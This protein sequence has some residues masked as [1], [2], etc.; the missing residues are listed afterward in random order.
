MKKSEKRLVLSRETVRNLMT[1]AQDLDLVVVAGG[2]CTYPTGSS[3]SDGTR[4]LCCD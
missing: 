1:P 4:R 3:P 2:S